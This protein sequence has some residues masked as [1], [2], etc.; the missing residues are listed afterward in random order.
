MRF[1]ASPRDGPVPRG[2]GVA[3]AGGGFAAYES[4]ADLEI[5]PIRDNIVDGGDV[6]EVTVT[7][8]TG[9]ATSDIATSSMGILDPDVSFVL[10]DDTE[11]YI[12][13]RGLEDEVNNSLA[14]QTIALTNFNLNLGGVD[15]HTGDAAFT[16]IPSAL[17]EYGEFVG[18]SFDLDSTASS[19]YCSSLSMTGFNINGI[20]AATNEALLQCQAVANASKVTINKA[21]PVGN[22]QIEL[23]FDWNACV[24][25]S[26]ITITVVIPGV[27]GGADQVVS[28]EVSVQTNNA[29]GN[30]KRKVNVNAGAGTT[31]KIT[32]TALDARGMPVKIANSIATA[33]KTVALK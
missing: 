32:V 15:F 31:V 22:Q 7:S 3:D 5:T 2:H 28:T 25:V 11:G 10:E 33:T 21:K 9:Y 6:V 29:I 23:D 4:T 30:E 26:K 12:A 1:S 24:G 18:Y 19:L 8:G 20:V 17:F 13:F 16:T 14:S 27:M